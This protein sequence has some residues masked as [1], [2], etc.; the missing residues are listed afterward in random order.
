MPITIRTNV[1]DTTMTRERVPLMFRVLKPSVRLALKQNLSRIPGV[2]HCLAAVI[3]LLFSASHF[4]FLGMHDIE[5]TLR[6]T[7][8]P[9]ATNWIIYVVA[10]LFEL[11]I[12]IACL[13]LRGRDSANVIILLFVGTMA[14]YRWALYYTGASN[15]HCLGLL[16]RLLHIN[17][18]QEKFIS[19]TTL[20]L[21]ALTSTHPVFRLLEKLQRASPR[22]VPTIVIAMTLST[23]ITRGGEYTIEIHGVLDAANYNPRTGEFHVNTKAHSTFVA[24]LSGTSWRVCITNLERGITWWAER[25][26]D[27]TNTYTVRPSNG[28]FWHTN[29][30]RVG[31]QMATI[32][33]SAVAITVDGDNF[34]AGLASVTYGLSPLAFKTNR[35]GSLEMPLPWTIVRHNPD[36]FGFK[37]LIQA[38]DGGRF[39]KEFTVVRNK[40]LDL[41]DPMELLRFELDYPE[42]LAHYNAYMSELLNR[43]ASPS[44][45]LRARY[46]C[47]AWFRTNNLLIPKASRLEVYL[48]ASSGPKPAR[49]FSLEALELRIRPG[50]EELIPDLGAETVVADYRYKRSDKHRIFK[51][52]EYTLKAGDVWRSGSDAELL[53]KAEDWMKHGRKYTDFA[54]NGKR[55]VMWLILVLFATPSLAIWLIKRKQQQQTKTKNTQ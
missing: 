29:H 3:I 40:A 22:L 32:S 11:A 25:L 24:S 37:W 19:I 2:L 15:C 53:A 7:V 27:G 10:A 46:E 48:P 14:W 35:E 26:Y 34:G 45:Y 31:M 50:I 18:A 36:A 6:N 49:I 8:F 17:H 23:Q 4:A 28:S 44:G 39:L 41:P 47:T 54:D 21:L 20:I 33:P 52:A 1:R 5:H 12:G 43:K 38:S 42:T 16:G 13:K 9:F 55:W 30:P 51:F